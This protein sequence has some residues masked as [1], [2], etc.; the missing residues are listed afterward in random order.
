MVTSKQRHT[1]ESGSD[2]Q[3]C[4]LHLLP[5]QSLQTH[6]A[7]LTHRSS[8]PLPQQKPAQKFKTTCNLQHA[9]SD[10]PMNKKLYIL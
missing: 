3:E 4:A 10:T 8:V 9:A 5:S 1:I 6:P 7:D 2:D